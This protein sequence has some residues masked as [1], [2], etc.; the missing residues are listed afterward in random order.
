MRHAGEKHA[1]YACFLRANE[2]SGHFPTHRTIADRSGLIAH[3][4]KAAGTA[5]YTRRF[6]ADPLIS[7][8]SSRLRRD[9]R[10][11]PATR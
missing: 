1:V 3:G 11:A 5:R 8:I 9:V 4:L 2:F 7:F 6:I 10:Q